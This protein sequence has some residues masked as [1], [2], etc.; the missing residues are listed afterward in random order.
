[1][2]DLELL[3]YT[4]ASELLRI[5]PSTLRKK[6]MERVVPCVKPFG[7]KGRTLFVKSDLLD[8]IE[9]HRVPVATET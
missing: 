7:R 6:V 5:K 4:E 1:M 8:F 9:K 2:S 3:D